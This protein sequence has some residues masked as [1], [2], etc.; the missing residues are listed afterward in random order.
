MKAITELYKN[1]LR[2]DASASQVYNFMG[3]NETKPLYMNTA[4]TLAFKSTSTRNPKMRIL[5]ANV[6]TFPLSK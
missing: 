1:D 6:G 5:I 4:T 3:L 2:T